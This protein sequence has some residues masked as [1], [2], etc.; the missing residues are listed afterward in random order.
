VIPATAV[1]RAKGK[2]IK[3]SMILRPGNEYL[4]RTHAI[5]SPKIEFTAAAIKEVLKDTLREAST[6]GEETISQNDFHPILELLTKT[7]ETGIKTSKLRYSKEKPI[8]IPNP[9]ITLGCFNLSGLI[10]EF[11]NPPQKD[12]GTVLGLYW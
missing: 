7:I 4:S 2:S 9:G 5:R 8:V 6:L 1:G 11:I 12:S 3:P 10:I